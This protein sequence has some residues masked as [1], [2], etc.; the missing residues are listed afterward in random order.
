MMSAEIYVIIPTYNEADNIQSLISEVLALPGPI[1]VIVVDDNSPD[2]TG[3]LAEEMASSHPGRVHVIH[4]PGKLGLG[5]AYV[6]G[7]KLALD[8]LGA[9]RI[10][11]MDAD[12]SHLPRYIP[13]MIDMSRT[14]HIVIG[15]RYVPGGGT[16]RW[17]LWRQVLSWGANTFAR[18]ALGLVAR[19]ATAGYR[20]YHREVLEAVPPELIRSSGYSFLVE[21][22]F[23]CEKRG[24]QV[25]EVPIIFED[26]RKGTSKI[27]KQEIIRAMQTVFRLVPCRLQKSEPLRPVSEN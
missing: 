3:R 9:S 13:A 2:G 11:T 20:L 14:R 5:T 26:R 10:I 6:A 15:S 8:H 21:M 4:R 24:F 16:A 25:G 19:D 23:N 22:L 7:F 1:G 18:L 27:S 17:P 12:F